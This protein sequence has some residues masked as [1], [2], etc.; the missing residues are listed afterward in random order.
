MVWQTN[1]HL[2]LRLTNY[3]LVAKS[4]S[5]TRSDRQLLVKYV[6]IT[7]ILVYL[8]ISPTTK[9]GSEYSFKRVGLPPT[10]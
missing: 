8:F 5:T 7:V 6:R 10:D 1:T 2:T 3:D 4:R 9:A